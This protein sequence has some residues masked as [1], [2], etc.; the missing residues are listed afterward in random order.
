MMNTHIPAALT[1]FLPTLLATLAV[2]AWGIE[3]SA[4]A[5]EADAA[6]SVDIDQSFAPPELPRANMPAAQLTAAGS[7]SGEN[8][9]RQSN[10]AFGTVVGRETVGLYTPELVRGFSPLAAGNVRLDG[11]YFDTVIEPT[12]R[13]SGAINI[14]IGPSV[15]GTAF[16][17]PSGI[18]DYQLRLPGTEF[19]ASALANATSYGEVR[20]ELDM[21]IPVTDRLSIGL[22]ATL[23]WLREG[24]GRRDDKFEGQLTLNWRPTNDLQL[25]PFIS[26]AYT[27]FDDIT[28]IYLP[29]GDFLPPRLPR[30]TRIG[31]DWSFR[32]DTEINAGTIIR[33]RLAKGWDFKAGLFRSE[34]ANPIDGENLLQDVMP[35]GTARQIVLR[36]PP[37]FFG[38]TSGEARITRTIEDGPRTHRLVFNV[39]G[40][41]TLRRFDG[42]D[43]IDLGPTQIDRRTRV[44]EPTGFDLDTQQRDRVRQWFAGF[45]YLGRWADVVEID[46]GLQY[47]D[48]R[49]RIG[50]IGEVPNAID[51][52]KWLYNAN[53]AI[54]LTSRLEL[55]G[56]YVTGIEES[57][58]A[59]GNADN[60]NEALP[61]ISTRQADL[62]L[63]WKLTDELSLIA[64]VFQLS[65]PYFSIDDNNVF[66]ELGTLRN[67][68]FE[69]SIAGMLT[70]EL[71]INLGMLLLDP[72]VRGEAVDAG[73]SGPRAIGGLAR[74]IEAS[75]D[76]RPPFLPGVSF[77]L[78]VSHRSPE[79]A[80]VNN[81]VEIP[82]RTLVALGGRYFFKLGGKSALL[83]VQVENLF[84]KQ[85]FE[86]VD[87]GAYQLIWPRRLLG[88]L[89][90]DF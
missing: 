29:A 42:T 15:L 2:P 35:D 26:F 45:A 69:T 71:S 60:R 5:A 66:R 20:G 14:L 78:A 79:T 90:V 27:P 61:A 7:R 84:D 51:V 68:G 50:F 21:A 16:P 53:I 76:W 80:T 73:I 49:K 88:Y 36:D 85:G 23:E 46:V 41:D 24:D 65:K 6:P 10:D 13:T 25:V 74:R 89:T 39:R 22:G 81:L 30:R 18:V 38:S 56:G 40:R 62:G 86:L 19:G 47:T 63:R 32:K 58:V 8:A 4:M 1:R 83:R 52:K 43:E 72:A 70:K 9:V 54:E 33:A 17:A 11:L 59:P 34:S 67:R 77:D 55:Y 12:D 57:G 87:A 82:T 3:T 44:P 48:Y 75:T 37:L 31:P 64:G 28:P